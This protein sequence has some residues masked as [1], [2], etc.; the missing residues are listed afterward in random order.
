MVELLVRLGLSFVV[1]GGLWF[2]RVQNATTLLKLTAV[3]GALAVMH[4]ITE[5]RGLRK[6]LVALILGGLDAGLLLAGLALSGLVDSFGFACIL[7]I[8]WISYRTRVSVQVLAPVTGAAILA[9]QLTLGL[10]IT[11]YAGAQSALVVL[12]LLV[13]PQP[14]VEKVNPHA[15]WIEM[16]RQ[17]R[18]TMWVDEVASPGEDILALRENYRQLRDQYRDLERR[19][20]K[21]RTIATV[22]ELV[23][24]PESAMY[25]KMAQRLRENLG[26]DDL[27]IF[28]AS[29]DRNQMMVRAATPEFPREAGQQPLRVNL[30]Q[31]DIKLLDALTQAIRGHA[32]DETR[33]VRNVLLLGDARL[34]GMISLVDNS[35]E[36][37]DEASSKLEDVSSFLAAWIRS[38]NTSFDSRQRAQTFEALYDLAIVG[39][40]AARPDKLANRALSTLQ[41]A[42]R[43]DGASIYFIEDGEEVLAANEGA[44]L[45]L[46]E[47]MSFAKGPGLQG[48]LAIG[49]PEL[50]LEDARGDQR[51]DPEEASRRRIGSTL[52]TPIYRSGQII[53][54]LTGSTHRMG[55][56]DEA[57]AESLRL[58]AGELSRAIT[59]LDEG[60]V[61]G[62]LL[63][64]SEFASFIRNRVG[65]IAVFDVIRKA[66]LIEA[67]GMENV[68]V[69]CKSFERRIRTRLP[70]EAA[71][72]K[73]GEGHYVV[74]LAG[75]IDVS[76][77]SR[78]ASDVVA[79]ANLIALPATDR[80]PKKP[81]PVRS[82][83]ANLAWS[84]S[85]GTAATS[86]VPEV[87]ELVA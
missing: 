66:L 14:T 83:V 56:I 80:A 5:H 67:H 19:S 22:A 82:K 11:A 86:D 84:N 36:K 29:M 6:G 30:E 69:A 39:E 52:I 34:V 15:A 61:T 48:W 1:A 76:E 35:T 87:D 12:L 7:P 32:G 71:Y 51:C 45:Y 31:P 63:P 73:R 65:S 18:E 33:K 72:C 37:L 20:S 43:I 75:V 79:T 59:R 16:V 4:A 26:V 68:Q 70:A 77:A 40:S 50:W 62:G 17:E 81:L 57:T 13:L 42:Q 21:D 23:G 24:L 53:G 9:A 74:F 85:P 49:A 41:G 38:T 10:G 58:V 2:A 3:F 78:W 28:S 54:F 47:A 44:R 60:K 64:Q 8:V 46:L 27:A 55:G 25:T